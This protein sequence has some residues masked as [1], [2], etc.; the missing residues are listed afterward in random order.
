MNP[1]LF[2]LAA[3][4]AA[5][6]GP[7]VMDYI[8]V[9]GGI[10]ITA[11]AVYKIGDI[12]MILYVLVVGLVFVGGVLFIPQLQGTQIQAVVLDLVNGVRELLA[13]YLGGAG[14]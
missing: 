6:S 2:M 9:I 4:A 8:K 5:A 14:P 11:I 3:Q 13:Q 1:I 7:S 10:I 12:K